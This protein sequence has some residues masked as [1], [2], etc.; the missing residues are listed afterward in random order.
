MQRRRKKKW[1]DKHGCQDER[2][3]K[4]TMKKETG[5]SGRRIMYKSH[6]KWRNGQE[7]NTGKEEEE[8][9]RYIVQ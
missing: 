2:E 9:L 4:K 6:V 8:Y 7:G 3:D 1:G 5:E